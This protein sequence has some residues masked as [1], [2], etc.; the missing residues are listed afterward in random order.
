MFSSIVLRNMSILLTTLIALLACSKDDK[1][2][3][4]TNLNYVFEKS[5]VEYK[6][7]STEAYNIFRIPSIVKSTNGTLL[8]FA[9]GRKNSYD[10]GDID[11]VLRRSFNNGET[12]E[13]LAVVWD[14]DDNACG[15]PAAVVDESTG[16]IY[17]LMTWA[18]GSDDSQSI[19]A[20]TGIDTRHVYFCYSSDDGESWST[21]EDITSS[22]KKDTW[23]SYGTGPAHG[24][25]ISEGE[26]S[27]RLVVPCHY[28]ELTAEGGNKNSHVIYSDDNG[29]TWNLGGEPQNESKNLDESTVAIL[30][31]NTLM[32]NM[33]VPDND[34]YRMTSTSDDGGLS[35]TTPITCEALIDPVCDGSLLNINTNGNC[36]LFFSN[37]ASTSRENMTIKKSTDDGETWSESY[38]VYT[39]LSGYSDIVQLSSTQLGILYEAGT[40]TYYDGIVYEIVDLADFD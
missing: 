13:A 20:G 3:S 6:N 26:Y 25:Q 40:S 14:D 33:R 8:A 15:S 19:N 39:G 5:S 35:W 34:N 18:N 31:D 10:S 7:E 36:T 27:G 2:D 38:S 4:N 29:K 28:T 22:V 24:I 21:P 32:L 37:P 9:E 11:I 1:D 23:G 12:W 30:S 17:L 16:I